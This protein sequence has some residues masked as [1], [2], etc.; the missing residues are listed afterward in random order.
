MNDGSLVIAINDTPESET[1][2]HWKEGQPIRRIGSTPR[3]LSTNITVTISGDLK[4]AFLVTRDDRR[5]IWMSKVV[6]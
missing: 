5:D 3:L 1:L 2:W 6:K 4:N